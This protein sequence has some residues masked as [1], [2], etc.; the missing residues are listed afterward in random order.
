MNW[1]EKWG[2]KVGRKR[3]EGGVREGIPHWSGEEKYQQY[4][5]APGLVTKVI[6]TKLKTNISQ[7]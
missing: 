4:E 6:K 7:E 1:K 5:H 2:G 3:G